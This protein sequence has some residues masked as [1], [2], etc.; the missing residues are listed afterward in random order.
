MTFGDVSVEDSR[1]LTTSN[2]RKVIRLAQ[3]QVEYLLHVQ[4]TLAAHKERL[5]GVA[6]QA[7][8]DGIEAR[9]EAQEHRARAKAAR[10]ELRKTRKALWTYEVLERIRSGTPLE[11]I[12]AD[13]ASASNAQI[14]DA[15]LDASFVS[16]GP[17]GDE[18]AAVRAFAKAAARARDAEAF[19]KRAAAAEKKLAEAE[20]RLAALGAEKAA[21]A[22]TTASA[23][24]ALEEA[25]KA[26]EL[27]AASSATNFEKRLA[28][29]EVELT[30]A[31]AMAE[32]AR[33]RAEAD[34]GDAE[35]AR[36]RADAAE[37]ANREAELDELRRSVR[38][39]GDGSATEAAAA[40]AAATAAEKRLADLER[41]DGE[42]ISELRQRLASKDEECARMRA[43]RDNL[44]QQLV[45]LASGVAT[46]L[47]SAHST[48]GY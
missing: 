6:E 26:A 27:R 3:C 42:I 20:T 11:E 38:S 45:Q 24:E 8:R 34:A 39:V 36:A 22:A 21:A 17:D 48:P 44:E 5:R 12:L 25:K 16:T 32:E 41:R 46:E 28:Q 15:S 13:S 10:A 40:I 7:Q 14:V 19:E 18:N 2:A 35:A 47:H 33:R 31:K 4:E 9:A 23:L 37:R 29:L 43:R 30:D 1:Y